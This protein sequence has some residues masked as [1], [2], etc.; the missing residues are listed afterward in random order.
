MGDFV[1]DHYLLAALAAERQARFLEHAQA[2]R[3]A[4]QTEAPPALTS[5]LLGALRAGRPTPRGRRAARADH[6]NRPVPAAGR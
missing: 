5:R 2:A 4:A 1:I 6:A 3:L